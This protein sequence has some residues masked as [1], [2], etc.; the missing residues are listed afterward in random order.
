MT[1][2]L[3]WPRWPASGVVPTTATVPARELAG[4]LRS[5]WFTVGRVGSESLESL[6]C[7]D[8]LLA[9]NDV[10]MGELLAVRQFYSNAPDWWW[11]LA[12]SL[13]PHC[14]LVFFFDEGSTLWTSV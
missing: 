3:T 13:I 1:V 14:F 4:R 5:D 6:T 2:A 7:S 8:S 11:R 9:G 10:Q 12:A